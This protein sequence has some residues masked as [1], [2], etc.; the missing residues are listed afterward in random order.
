M[1]LSARTKKK[2]NGK[3]A[4]HNHMF[5]KQICQLPQ[6]DYGVVPCN[7]TSS[8]TY[9]TIAILG[10]KIFGTGKLSHEPSAGDIFSYSKLYGLRLGNRHCCE[11]LVGT[12]S[13]LYMFFAFFSHFFHVYKWDFYCGENSL[14]CGTVAVIGVVALA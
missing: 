10:D 14:A 11:P 12:L 6:W 4:Q 13:M 7:R 3:S 2:R 9:T 8:A 1:W 5:E